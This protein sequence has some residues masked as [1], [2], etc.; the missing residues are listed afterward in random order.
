LSDDGNMPR[1]RP[2]FVHLS[3]AEVWKAIA[4][5]AGGSVG[6]EVTRLVGELTIRLM[7]RAGDRRNASAGAVSYRACSGAHAGR[8]GRNR[9]AAPLSRARLEGDAEGGFQRSVLKPR[10]SKLDF[11]RS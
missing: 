9:S 5:D 3:E 2:Q 6:A 1:A 8:G 7:A 11:V 10:I 4:E